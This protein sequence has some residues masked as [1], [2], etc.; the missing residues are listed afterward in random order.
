ME[1]AEIKVGDR[2]MFPNLSLDAPLTI[3]T[4]KG[5]GAKRVTFEGLKYPAYVNRQRTFYGPVTS[6]DQEERI[7]AAWRNL[8]DRRDRMHRDFADRERKAMVIFQ[9]IVEEILE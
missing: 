6:D 7:R 2:V 9:T 3:R 8:R 5:I 4:I 1:L